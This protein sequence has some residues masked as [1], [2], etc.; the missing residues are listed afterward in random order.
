[1]IK[2]PVSHIRLKWHQPGL[3]K[4]NGINTYRMYDLEEDNPDLVNT[5]AWKFWLQQVERYKDSTLIKIKTRYIGMFGWCLGWFN[6]WTF[7]KERS[8]EELLESFRKHV[9]GFEGLH[10]IE[11]PWCLMGAEDRGRWKGPC[12]CVHCQDEN[13]TRMDH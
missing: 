5:D 11:E 8:D 3:E 7:V 4:P 13:K 1:M 9:N 6:H 12:H 10:K 2:F